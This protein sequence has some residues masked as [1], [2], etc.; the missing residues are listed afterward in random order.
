[1]TRD[2]GAQ[3]FEA[4]LARLEEIAA[5]LERGEATLEEGLVLFE[6]GIRLSRRCQEL[7]ADAEERIQRLTAAGA[8]FTLTPF[9]PAGEEEER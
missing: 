4:A 3:T 1:M 8:G 6:E 5:K 9:T 7:L 2:E